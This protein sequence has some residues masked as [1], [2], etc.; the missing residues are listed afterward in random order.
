MV[1]YMVSYMLSDGFLY[2]FLRGFL[3]GFRWFPLDFPRTK[4]AHVL[5]WHQP[6]HI[7]DEF[8]EHL[9]AFES[10]LSKGHCNHLVHACMSET[11]TEECDD[12]R[13]SEQ[14]TNIAMAQK[15]I[16]Q[17]HDYPLSVIHFFGLY[18]VPYSFKQL[19]HSQH[20]AVNSHSWAFDAPLWSFIIP[21][22]TNGSSWVPMV[23]RLVDPF[24]LL[25]GVPTMGCSPSI[26]PYI[27]L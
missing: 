18:L 27:W 15:N 24:G 22:C 12:M 16:S 17:L 21:S 23:Y 19:H 14:S 1:S 7:A 8:I 26:T 6:W 3:N 2:G 20:R 11:P 9:P 10:I 5:G 25:L 4:K 13:C